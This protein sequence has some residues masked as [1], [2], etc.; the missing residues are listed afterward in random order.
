MT[1]WFWDRLWTLVPG[2]IIQAITIPKPETVNIF[3]P[4]VNTDFHSLLSRST[5]LW[6]CDLLKATTKGAPAEDLTRNL[7]DPSQPLHP[8]AL[9]EGGGNIV[10][11]AMGPSH[12][13]IGL[14]VTRS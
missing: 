9:K 6:K 14:N 2:F 5:E 8:C 3:A 13:F 7:W 1:D 4:T 10:H 11:G 12:V